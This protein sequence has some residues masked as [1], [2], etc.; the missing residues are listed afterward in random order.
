MPDRGPVVTAPCPMC[1]NLDGTVNSE[2]ADENGSCIFG[3]GTRINH[4]EGA[5]LCPRCK[6]HSANEVECE[7]CGTVWADWAMGTWERAA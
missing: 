3:C 4:D 5:G 6:D 2:W 1:Q 7:S